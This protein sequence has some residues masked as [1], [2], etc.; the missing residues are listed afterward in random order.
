M[1]TRKGWNMMA[2]V[3]AALVAACADPTSPARSLAGDVSRDVSTVQTQ[4][5]PTG[6]DWGEVRVCKTI[7]ADDPATTFNYTYTVTH[8]IPAGAPG[9]PVAFSINALPGQTVCNDVYDSGPI[10]GSQYDRVVIVEGA[11][12]AN[13]SLSN[14]D[15]VRYLGL[16]YTSPVGYFDTEDEATRTAT[17]YVNSDEGRIVTFTNDYT[18]P[19]IGCTYTKGWYQNKNGAPTVVAVDGR[20]KLEAQTILASVPSPKLD[21]NLGVTWG[22]DNLLHNLYQQLLA[23]LLNGGAAG[24]LAVQNAI[25]DAQNGTGGT[26]L[27]ITTTLTHDEMAA[28]TATLSAFNEGTYA[29]WP[30]CGFDSQ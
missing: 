6:L 5:F 16:N 13:W 21:K 14:I 10:T 18:P 26:G 30:H 28:L 2:L 23:A 11:A 15:V 19:V 3:V 25:T 20:S 9:A 17:T 24:P 8:V 29:G 7:A 22:S 1:M 27:D 12:P 4:T